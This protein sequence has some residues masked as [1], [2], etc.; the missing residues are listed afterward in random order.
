[1]KTKFIALILTAFFL[2]GCDAVTKEATDIRGSTPEQL[3]T[4]ESIFQE[5][6]QSCHGVKARGVVPDWQKKQADGSLPAPPLNGT[7]HAWHHNDKILLRTINMGSVALGG[8]MPAFKDKL[9]K[10][11]KQAV[12][13]YIKNLWPDELYKSWSKRN[14]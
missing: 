2:A 8:S 13:A 11:E 4:G 6:C 12:L 1:M 7:A 9:S 14:G 10:K 5:N 3:A